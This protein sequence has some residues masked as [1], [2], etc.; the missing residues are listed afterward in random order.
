MALPQALHTARHLLESKRSWRGL[1]YAH[2]Y[3]WSI[4]IVAVIT[5]SLWLLQGSATIPSTTALYLVGV[6]LCAT[7]AG[8][9]PAVL[10]A[11]LSFLAFKFFFVP[12]IFT[13]T[14]DDPE[15]VLRLTIFLGTAVAAGGI[16]VR[17]REQALAAQRRVTE[18]TALYDLSQ[19]ISAQLEFDQIAPLVVATTVRLLGC[20]ASALF[21]YEP[22]GALREVAR[23]GAAP[24]DVVMVE[25]ALR[26]TDENLGVLR[27]ALQSERAQLD[28]DAVRLLDTLAAQAAL[29][30]QRSRLAQAAAQAEALAES[31]RLKS[32]LLS[33]V[34]HDFRTPLAAITTAADELVAEDVR[35]TPA[36]RRNFGRV[37]RVEAERL[38]RLLINL[39]DL[40][41]LEGGALQPQ[42]GWYNIAEIVGVVL[43]RLGADLAHRQ[44]EVAVADDLPLVP[45]DYVQLEQVLWNLLQNAIKYSPPDSPIT[46]SAAIEDDTLLLSIADR[47]HGIPTTERERVFE[48]F[49]R[50]QSPKHGRV[51][52][53]GIGLAI[54]KGLTEAHG[55]TVEIHGRTGGG[56]VAQVRLPLHVPEV[57]AGEAVAG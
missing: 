14:V 57:T 11:C 1:I 3:A 30:L 43:Q 22:P 54:C 9:W 35:W 2:P 27:V 40:S 15:D 32:T 48:K 16:A 37:I 31:D 41:R 29:A 53:T 42:R 18:T 51:P 12:P 49:Y 39:L 10:C 25:S 20:K 28:P 4:G 55:G 46:I 45:V 52:G 47:G 17:L 44:V 38:N 33:A 7:S 26:G 34:S 21:L 8:R 19:A 50:L 36:A 13:M 24:I 6:L 23:A 56:S 5:S